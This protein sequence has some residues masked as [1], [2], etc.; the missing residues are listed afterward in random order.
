MTDIG[1]DPQPNVGRLLEGF[2]LAMR[3][4]LVVERAGDHFL[5]NQPW[6]LIPS[7]GSH[8]ITASNASAEMPILFPISQVLER[9]PAVR[10]TVTIEPLL[11]SSSQAYAKVDINDTTGEQGPKDPAGPFVLAA[12]VSDSGEVGERPSRMVV[13]AS[14]QFI[15]PSQNLG[16]SWRTRTCS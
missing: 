13:M 14:S 4:W 10:R 11:A 5:P 16:G 15:F 12:A 7:V 2:G 6:L 1:A 9:L 8:P 3:P